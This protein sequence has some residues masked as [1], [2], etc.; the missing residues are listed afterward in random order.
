M[1]LMDDKKLLE[2]VTVEQ[3]RQNII[4]LRAKEI[5]MPRVWILELIDTIESQ[6]QEN[7]QLRNDLAGIGQMVADYDTALQENEQLQARN[8]AMREALDKYISASNI[9]S[10]HYQGNPKYLLPL[11]VA[12]EMAAKI[13]VTP[14]HN[15][16]D[17]DALKKAKQALD[18]WDKMEYCDCDQC[19]AT[20]EA[21]AAI[22][23]AVGE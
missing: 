5:E 3:L 17:V 12:F 19:K 4:L 23:K 11:S 7:E 18:M 15:P 14:Y 22:D 1:R 2:Q 8:G 9:I 16:A 6:Q 10:K 20:R 13:E 21:I